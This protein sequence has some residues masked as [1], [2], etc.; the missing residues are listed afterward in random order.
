MNFMWLLS[1]GERFGVKLVA[2]GDL[3]PRTPCL[4]TC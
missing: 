4:V 2:K 3:P 1:Y